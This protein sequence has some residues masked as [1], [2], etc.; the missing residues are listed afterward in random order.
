MLMPNM[1]ERTRDL[2]IPISTPDGEFIAVFSEK[3][4][5]RL[6]FPSG[7]SRRGDGKRAAKLTPRLRRWRA[8]TA[9]A[10]KHA[11]SG[12][13]PGALPP[14]D[15]SS[16]TR[17]QQIVWRALR[18]IVPGRTRSYGEV[19]RAIGRA[20]AVRAVGGACGANPIPVFIP[21]HRVI[22]ADGGLGGFSNGWDWKRKLLAREGVRRQEPR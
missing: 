4:L 12:R 19:A 10:L 1:N 15:L 22:A 3:G 5:C 7:A 18:R 11:I 9:R 17:F 20:R 2:E 8:L 6:E 14:L 21:C 16:G 13:R